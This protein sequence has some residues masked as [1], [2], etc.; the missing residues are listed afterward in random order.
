MRDRFGREITYLRI[1][2]TDRCNLRCRYCMPAGGIKLL[3]H[4][5]ILSFEEIADIVRAGVDMGITKIRLT[6]GEPLVRRG[7]ARLV[8]TLANIEGVDDLAMTTNAVLLK[9]YATSLANAGLHRVNISLDTTDAERYRRITRC[10]DIEDVFAGIAAARQAEL[11]PIKLNCVANPFL[12]ESDVEAVKDFGRSNRLQVRVI[13][14]MDFAAGRFSVVEGGT[15]GDCQRCNRLRLSSD[16]RLRPCL[17]SDVSFA[18][19]GSS[20]KRAIRQAIAAKPSAGGPCEHNWM[21]G[22]GG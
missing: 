18:V 1:S 6:G 8:E 12:D 9:R 22:I 10:G 11:E 19:R 21:H 5:S 7:I 14:M 3:K 15:G 16:G 17:F 20:A 2:V 4:E 13:R